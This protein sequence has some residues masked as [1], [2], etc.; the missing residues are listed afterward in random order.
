MGK[1]KG[2]WFAFDYFIVPMILKVLHVVFAVA[3]LASGIAST[4]LFWADLDWRMR[5][6]AIIGTILSPFVVRVIFEILMVFFRTA[7]DIHAIRN[8]CGYKNAELPAGEL[9]KEEPVSPEP[10]R[11]VESVPQRQPEPPRSMATPA[12]Q[13]ARR[14]EAQRLEDLFNAPPVRKQD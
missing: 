11:P 3:V 6:V 7:E 8:C 4:V 9:P 12:E 13:D 1:N 14:I 5:L 10:P 2:S